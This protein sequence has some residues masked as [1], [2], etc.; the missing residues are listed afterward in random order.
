MTVPGIAVCFSQ[1]VAMRARRPRRRAGAAGGRGREPPH[2]V[3]TGAGARATAGAD[4]IE[5][6]MLDPGG[7]V[8]AV[9]AGGAGDVK[10][11]TRAGEHVG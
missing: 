4:H 7:A 11:G 5:A 1:A 9:G 2:P 10:I 8:R 6:C 3:A